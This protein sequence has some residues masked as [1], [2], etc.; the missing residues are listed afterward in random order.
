MPLVSVELREAVDAALARPEA[1]T[2][3]RAIYALLQ[4]QIDL[5][6][7]ICSASGKCCNFESYGHRLYVTTLEL[8]TFVVDLK[9]LPVTRASGPCAAPAKSK[10]VKL[11]QH[12]ARAGGPCHDDGLSIG[13]GCP[14]QKDGLCSVHAIRPFGCRVFFCDPTADDWQKQQYERFHAELKQLHDRFDVPYLYVEWR[15]ALAALG[16][17]A[18]DR[19]GAI[20]KGS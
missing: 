11:T 12:S 17:D 1:S 2:S 16:I 3:V 7:P 9:T 20:A 8:A 15:A 18:E 4:S 6:K 13:P 19:N 5:R 10:V 14:L